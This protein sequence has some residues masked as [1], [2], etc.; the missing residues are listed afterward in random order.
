MRFMIVIFRM[1]LWT[2]EVAWT[3]VNDEALLTAGELSF[4]TDPRFQVSLKPSESDWV[5]IIR[6]ILRISFSNDLFFS[7]LYEI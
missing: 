3:R 2:L 7:K 1:I 4:T 5:L 6:C